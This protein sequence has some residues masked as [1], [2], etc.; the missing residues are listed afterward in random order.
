[1]AYLDRLRE[2]RYRSPS[3][4]ELAFE[5]RELQRSGEKKAAIHEAPEADEATVQDLGNAALRFTLEAFISGPDY[6]RTADAFFEA[7]RERGP[8]LLQHP[9]WGDV[10]ALPL[11]VS[12]TEGF[13]DGMRRAVFQIEFVRVPEAEYVAGAAYAEGQIAEGLEDAADSGAEEIGGGIS[14]ADAAEEERTKGGLK[15]SL[16]DFKERIAAAAAVSDEIGSELERAARE[17]EDNLDA[18]ILDPITLA[19]SWIAL[20]RTPARAA[21][22]VKSKVRGYRAS[23]ETLAGI[24]LATGAQAAEAAG[25]TL[26]FFAFLLGMCE[27]ALTGEIADRDEA[28]SLAGE[29]RGTLSDALAAVETDEAAAEYVAPESSLARLRALVALTSDLLLERSFSLRAERRIV[30]AADRTPLDLAYELHGDL[31]GLDDLIEQNGL[32]DEELFLIPRGREVR[33]YAE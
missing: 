23:V 6:D 16:A 22:S 21:A 14:P 11:S 32:S 29:V 28:V 2:A 24:A 12:Q 18:L 9:R 10:P 17:L 31:D 30:L 8:G 7:L 1:M 15:A 27:S 13:V 20:V 5:F 19:R 33:Y 4:A 25:R 26:Q 3:G